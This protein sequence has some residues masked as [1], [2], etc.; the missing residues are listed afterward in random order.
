MP[1]VSVHEQFRQKYLMTMCLRDLTFPAD[2]LDTINER[3]NLDTAIL[4]AI[5]KTRYLNPRLPVL[6]L[7]NLELMWAYADD[8]AHHHRF[9]H[10]MRVSPDV[11]DIILALI[12]DHPVFTNNSNN[13]QAPVC[14]Q[15]AVTLYRLGRYGNA[16]SVKDIAMMLGI[17]EGAAH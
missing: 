13:S 9:V 6:K 7:G 8:P 1:R 5:D 12:Q 10:M 15:L 11:F 14:T 16:A 2:D 3:L 4:S 17:S